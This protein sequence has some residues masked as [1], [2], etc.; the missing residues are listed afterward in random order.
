RKRIRKGCR[1]PRS[2]MRFKAAV[3][4]GTPEASRKKQYFTNIAY[5]HPPQGSSWDAAAGLP[6]ESI[7][8]LMQQSSPRGWKKAVTRA[9]TRTDLR[10]VGIASCRCGR[11]R[12]R[13]GR[14]AV[15]G[16]EAADGLLG[17]ADKAA[18]EQLQDIGEGRS[19]AAVLR[20]DEMRRF[21]QHQEAVEIALL[22]GDP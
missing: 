21:V 18:V 20:H 6:V 12:G 7:V 1:P 11:G 2:G 9:I 16:E 17:N 22:D 4:S 19:V 14:Q 10:R 8:A 13:V 5:R 15:A 3:R